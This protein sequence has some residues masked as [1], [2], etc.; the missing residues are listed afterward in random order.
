MSE[1]LEEIFEHLS[2]KRDDN[3]LA[4]TK[5]ERIFFQKASSPSGIAMGE[6]NDALVDKIS[7]LYAEHDSIAE[8]IKEI[9]Q[10]AMTPRRQI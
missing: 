2:A 9:T 6:E 5:L 4:I 10:Q 8:E 1:T 7:K 3:A